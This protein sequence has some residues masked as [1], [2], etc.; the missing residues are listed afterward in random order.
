SLLKLLKVLLNVLLTQIWIRE[1]LQPPIPEGQFGSSLKL[2][3]R[4]GLQRSSRMTHL[5]LHEVTHP[6]IRI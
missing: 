6:D 1:S 3:T 2:P 4:Q 5:C